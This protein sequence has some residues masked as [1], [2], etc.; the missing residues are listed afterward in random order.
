METVFDWNF[1]IHEL[2]L[3]PSIVLYRSQNKNVKWFSIRVNWLLF[4]SE[5]NFYYGRENA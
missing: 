3:L 5:V 4:E 1:K 2:Y